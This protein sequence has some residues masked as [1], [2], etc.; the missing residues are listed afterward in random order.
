MIGGY[1]TVACS[2]IDYLQRRG[3]W[4]FIEEKWGVPADPEDTVTVLEAVGRRLGCLVSGGMVD[5]TLAGR[6]FLESFSAG[7]LG[8]F[9]LES[10]TMPAAEKLQ[11]PEDGDE[12][13]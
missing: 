5:F 3:L 13:E 12:D 6:R 11:A 2:L 10:P 4:H 9:S 7:K 1:D 8:S